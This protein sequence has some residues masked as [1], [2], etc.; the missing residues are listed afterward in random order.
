MTNAK[1]YRNLICAGLGALALSHVSLSHAAYAQLSPPVGWNYG[2]GG[3]ATYNAAKSAAQ[4]ASEALGRI[5][6]NAAISTGGKTISVPVRLPL[7]STAAKAAAAAI[8]LHP[9]L[10]TI[11]AV[12]TWLGVA[13]MVYD[14]A[15]GLWKKIDSGA[16]ASDGISWGVAGT[17][18][19]APHNFSAE[20]AC[21]YFNSRNGYEHVRVSATHCYGKAPDGSVLGWAYLTRHGVS[22]CPVGW[23]VTSAGCTQSPPMKTVSQPEFEQ[24]VPDARPMPPELPGVVW[25]AVWPVNAPEIQPIFIPTGNPVPNPN[26]DPAKPQSPSNQPYNQPGVRVVPAPTADSPW[27][28][29]LQPV[30]RPV[31]S[32]VAKPEPAPEVNPD[33]T[34]KPDQGDKPKE[35]KDERDLCEKNPDILACQKVDTEVDNEEIPKSQK[36]VSYQAE[37]IWGG[38]AC[39]ADKY[40]RIGGQEMK[41]V[42]WSRDC[43]FITDSVKPVALAICL[44]IVIGILYGGLKP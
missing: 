26:Y 21:R 20:S 42:D 12:A 17:A 8:Y 15:D 11:A 22:S 1:F 35:D 33:G 37:S 25:P 30:D 28:V 32:P 38:G 2:A 9:G 34:P 43:Q 7:A 36:T 44:I 13:G 10:R 29:D 3:A 14:V 6:A 23:Y 18:A 41:V 19:P 16:Q 24:M 27:Q 31:D 5:A 40:T 4:V 39:P